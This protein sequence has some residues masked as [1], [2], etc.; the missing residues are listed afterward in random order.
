MSSSLGEHLQRAD[1]RA[2]A[3]A[4]LHRDHAL[5]AATLQRDSSS[6]GVSLP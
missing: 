4:G 6:I 2:V 1:E 3:L 5:P